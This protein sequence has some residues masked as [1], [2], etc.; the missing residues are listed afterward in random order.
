MCDDLIK[1]LEELHKPLKTKL[2]Q[3]DIYFDMCVE[4]SQYENIEMFSKKVKYP[5][6]TIKVVRGE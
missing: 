6:K 1:Q 2:P 3:T 5:C 4:C